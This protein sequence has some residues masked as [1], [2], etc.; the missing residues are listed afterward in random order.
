VATRA[1]SLEQDQEE[2]FQ[3]C[4]LMTREE[5]QRLAQAVDL[6]LARNREAYDTQLATFVNQ[7]ARADLEQ[8]QVITDLD[9]AL[10]RLVRPVSNTN[11]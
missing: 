2:L 9:L 5:L 7:A 3:R 11:R 4:S 10:G 1:A 6:A 8:R